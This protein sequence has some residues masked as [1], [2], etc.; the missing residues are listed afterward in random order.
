MDGLILGFLLCV[1]THVFGEGVYVINGDQVKFPATENCQKEG[2][3]LVHRLN[4]ISTR[5]V[6]QWDDGWKPGSGYENRISSNKSVIFNSAN[7]NDNGLYEFTCG[8]KDERIQLHVVLFTDSSVTEGDTVTF[9]F[10]SVTAGKRGK[11]TVERDG[12]PVFQLVFLSRVMTRGAGFD[13]RVSVS[14]RWESQGDL[15]VT[16]KRATTRDQGDYLLYV[17]DKDNNGP[18]EDLSAVRLR[19]TERVPDQTTSSPPPV[20]P[21]QS[22]TD[23][24]QK[25]TLMTAV[26]IT[27]AVVFIITAT[28]CVLIGWFM[29]THSSRGTPGPGVARC[30]DVGLELLNS[31]PPRDPPEADEGRSLEG[32]HAE[33]NV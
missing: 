27:A 14:P 26:S 28:V 11:F 6:A 29:K 7:I 5:P 25:R 13:E 17:Q 2:A 33:S 12:E 3:T 15:T 23:E 1:V 10:F 16:L 31:G 30:S 4:D 19:V 8:S 18:R 20:C 21:T 22:V 9:P 24:T 32:S